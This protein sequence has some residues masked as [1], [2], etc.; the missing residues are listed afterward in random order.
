MAGAKME[1][2]KEE[3]AHVEHQ[4]A[5]Y[6]RAEREEPWGDL[7]VRMLADHITEQIGPLFFNQG[8]DAA[9][10]VAHDITERLEVNLDAAKRLP[11]ARQAGER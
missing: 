10:R 2:T 1:L 8:I 11:P 7:A 5:S 9:Q 6:L 3:R 4:L